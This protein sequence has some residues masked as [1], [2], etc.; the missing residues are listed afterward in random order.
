MIHFLLPPAM[1]RAVSMHS[2]PTASSSCRQCKLLPQVLLAYLD[3]E[4][5]GN[6][7]VWT[8]F[9][10]Q[11][12]CIHAVTLWVRIKWRQEDDAVGIEC[13]SLWG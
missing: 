12:F 3:G 8:R 7:V 10:A 11:E 9:G 4:V 13:M 2:I 5:E 6:T 1:K